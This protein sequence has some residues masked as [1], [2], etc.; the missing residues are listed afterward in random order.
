VTACLYVRGVSVII[1]LI[2]DSTLSIVT[3]SFLLSSEVIGLPGLFVGSLNDD[4]NFL[5]EELFEF[6]NLCFKGIKFNEWLLS[7]VLLF[8]LDSSVTDNFLLDDRLVFLILDSK[9]MS[10]DIEWSLSLLDTLIDWRSEAS[11]SIE[12]SEFSL[13]LLLFDSLVD[14]LFLSYRESSSYLFSRFSVSIYGSFP[15]IWDPWDLLH[16]SFVF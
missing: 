11:L 3:L 14:A 13:W 6:F 9:K 1:F 5:L 12:L 15:L 10:S 2:E 7:F 16:E 8:E 4:L